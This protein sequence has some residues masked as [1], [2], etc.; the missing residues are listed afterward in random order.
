VYGIFGFPWRKIVAK[1]I[2]GTVKIINLG[3][4]K[5]PKSYNCPGPEC[6]SL[7]VVVM[8]APAEQLNVVVVAK[9]EY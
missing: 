7:T 1:K 9:K 6:K 5:K 4:I 3:A 8:A 2:E